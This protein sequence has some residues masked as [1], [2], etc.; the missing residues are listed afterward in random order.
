VINI[1]SM[2]GL[3]V[4]PK[5]NYSYAASKAGLHHM[6]GSIAKRLGPEHIT[7]NALAPGF[8]ESKMTQI[9]PEM[10]KQVLPLVP[11]RRIGTPEDV[12]GAAIYLASRAGG[13]ITGAVI[14]V[15]GGMT[16]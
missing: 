7:V 14:P 10:M 16:L 4:G 3:R 12:A 13:F 6:T 1:G 15:E 9:P 8:F 5:Q 11:R 2:G